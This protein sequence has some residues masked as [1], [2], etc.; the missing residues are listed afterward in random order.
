MV[1][2]EKPNQ[3]REENLNSYN[4]ENYF[5]AYRIVKSFISVALFFFLLTL[6]GCMSN[7]SL[8]P[9]ISEIIIEAEDVSFDSIK[10]NISQISY[11]L[12]VQKF[13][14]SKQVKPE[15]IHF[16]VQGQNKVINGENINLD[17]STIVLKKK[18]ER[19]Y[20]IET[21]FK[22]WGINAKLEIDKSV[23]SFTLAYGNRQI[24]LNQSAHLSA[25]ERLMALVLLN[26]FDEIRVSNPRFENKSPIR[27]E[28]EAPINRAYYGYTIGWGFTREQSID[29]EQEVR[30]GAGE[31]I[32]KFAC[33]LLGTNTSCFYESIGCVTV[34]TFKCTSND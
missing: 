3:S 19:K 32:K 22:A 14:K 12:G 20:S 27:S 4:M 33:K 13:T 10:T 30:D 17:H 7:N 23:N 1:N 16:E 28:N 18:S 5:S 26:Y 8:D 25:K 2:P 21:T 34:S 31:E 29:D 6:G 11:L 9:S 15:E 24:K